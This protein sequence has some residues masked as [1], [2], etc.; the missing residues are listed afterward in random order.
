MTFTRLL[1]SSLRG[2][3]IAGLMLGAALKADVDLTRVSDKWIRK[4]APE[5]LTTKLKAEGMEC[6]GYFSSANATAVLIHNS[7]KF[8][9]TVEPSDFDKGLEAI[10]RGFAK[11]ANAAKTPLEKNE[12]V[13]KEGSACFTRKSFTTGQPT[14]C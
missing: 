4:E 3:F 13:E 5:A 14:W 12:V 8:P 2:A 7:R 1:E 10:Q 9:E 11:A 6:H